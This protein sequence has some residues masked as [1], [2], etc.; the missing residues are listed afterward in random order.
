MILQEQCIVMFL[1]KLGVPVISIGSYPIS[2]CTVYTNGGKIRSNEAHESHTEISFPFL[3]RV[4][5]FF[6][7]LF[8]LNFFNWNFVKHKEETSKI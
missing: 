6:L 2:A 3:L 4:F 5:V 8:F 1:K 7:S